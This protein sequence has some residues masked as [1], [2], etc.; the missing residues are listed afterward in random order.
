M[1]RLFEQIS[2][3]LPNLALEGH[4]ER[5]EQLEVSKRDESVSAAEAG[6]PSSAGVLWKA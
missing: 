2:T 4:P 3:S 5:A 6:P 1:K